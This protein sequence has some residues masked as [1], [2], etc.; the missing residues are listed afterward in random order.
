[1]MMRRRTKSVDCL[2]TLLKYIVSYC[3]W[4][5]DFLNFYH[6]YLS[7]PILSFDLFSFKLLPMLYYQ[8]FLGGPG[9]MVALMNLA[10]I[11][12]TKTQTR[13][14]PG[15]ARVGPGKTRTLS[16][17]SRCG[18]SCCSAADNTAETAVA[19]VITLSICMANACQSSKLPCGENRTGLAELHL[20]ESSASRPIFSDTSTR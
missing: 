19:L 15:W 13:A 5:I 18:Q 11:E 2:T 7:L 4:S 3:H 10:S 6:Y 20:F 12:D 17:S 1:M 8:G 14:I 9:F 16:M